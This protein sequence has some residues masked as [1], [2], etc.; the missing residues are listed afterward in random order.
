MIPTP[1][2]WALVFGL[3]ALLIIVCLT[4]SPTPLAPGL[5]PYH[6]FLARVYEAVDISSIDAVLLTATAL[7]VTV[8]VTTNRVNRAPLGGKD[9]SGM[10][11]SD[12][13]DGEGG[14]DASDG[15]SSGDASA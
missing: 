15:S 12:P 11:S 14:A 9:V 13:R 4:A 3:S 5:E 10:Y 1:I 7:V 8:V 2:L 6:A